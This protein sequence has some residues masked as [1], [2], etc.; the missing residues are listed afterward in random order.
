MTMLPISIICVSDK[1]TKTLMRSRHL[2]VGQKPGRAV[3]TTWAARSR[4][5]ELT[6]S[7]KTMKG[8]RTCK[9]SSE[10]K[11]AQTIVSSLLRTF[12]LSISCTGAYASLFS[13]YHSWHSLQQSY[14][15]LSP[16][17]TSILVQLLYCKSLPHTI[18]NFI[19]YTNQGYQRHHCVWV[20]GDHPGIHSAFCRFHS[21]AQAKFQVG[22]PE[23]ESALIC[24]LHHLHDSAAVPLRGL[25]HNSVHADWL[26]VC[27]DTP[28]RDT[29]VHQ[30]DHHHALLPQNH[31]QSLRIAKEERRAWGYWWPWGTVCGETGCDENHKR[32]RATFKSDWDRNSIGELWI[33]FCLRC[34]VEWNGC[35]DTL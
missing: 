11:S 29:P 4:R 21:H 8:T 12:L 19:F 2:A 9:V 10:A 14:I 27:R 22:L 33:D 7:S 15:S 23:D 24:S 35:C 30:R 20:W 26:G 32:R 34:S 3:L 28:R 13:L 6:W 31:R 18:V 17:E 1:T 25:Q 16:Q 5:R